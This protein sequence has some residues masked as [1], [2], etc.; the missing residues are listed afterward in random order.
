MARPLL[1]LG[2]LLTSVA[3]SAAGPEV[4]GEA[5]PSPNIVFIVLDD[6]NDYVG[7]MGGH[8][9]SQTPEIDSL[10]V[11]S[12]V[13]SNAHS[14]VPVCAP[15]RASMFSGI[16]AHN[17]K[18]YG[19]A[20]WFEN[21]VLGNSKTLMEFFGENGYD[22]L[23]VGKVMHHLKRDQWT[24]FGPGPDYGPVWFDG[25]NKTA[26]PSVPKPFADIGRSTAR[27]RR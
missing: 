26:H 7:Y 2:A 13:F 23:G 3:C 25:E 9:Q 16:Y 6:L 4:P 8:P 14:N 12:I 22:T 19:F 20:K 18:N 21:P 17:S 11:Q 5:Q 1:T 15:A 24:T 27:S 10:A